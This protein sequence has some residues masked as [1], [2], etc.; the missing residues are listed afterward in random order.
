MKLFSIISV[1]ALF[2]VFS[3]YLLFNNQ[4]EP[5]LIKQIPAS[6]PVERLEK[7]YALIT[8]FASWCETCPYLHK[9]LGQFSKNKNLE[10]IGIGWMDSNENIKKFLLTYGN[11]FKNP[12]LDERGE[13]GIAFGIKG[14]PETFLVNKQ[15]KILQHYNG[16]LNEK[17]IETIYSVIAN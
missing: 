1:F 9:Q 11:F 4:E 14:V 7:P 15:G 3:F 6:F 16:L 2:L 10:I 5:S 12:I 13:L 17:D 8:F